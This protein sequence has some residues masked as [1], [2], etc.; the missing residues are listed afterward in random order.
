[1]NLSVFYIKLLVNK[2]VPFSVSNSLK[3]ETEILKIR[4]GPETTNTFL[5][6]EAL[7]YY[8]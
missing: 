1:M 8:G 2:N 6:K 7:F 3:A 5:F 4:K